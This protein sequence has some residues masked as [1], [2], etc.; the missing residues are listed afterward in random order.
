MKKATLDAATLVATLA[1]PA[2]AETTVF[3]R[4]Q[5]VGVWEACISDGPPSPWLHAADLISTAVYDTHMNY[6]GD[7][8]YDDHDDGAASGR[9]LVEQNGCSSAARTSIQQ[10]PDRY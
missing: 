8:E 9:R 4:G 7:A 1:T 3:F 5:V 6:Y 2:I 10:L